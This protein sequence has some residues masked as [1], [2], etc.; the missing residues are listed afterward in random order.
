MSDKS[1]DLAKVPIAF[2]MLLDVDLENPKI[3]EKD[4]G[5]SDPET[6]DENLDGFSSS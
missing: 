4:T 3:I 2:E 1:H 5:K 6:R